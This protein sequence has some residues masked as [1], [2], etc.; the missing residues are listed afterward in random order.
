MIVPWR[1]KTWLFSVPLPLKVLLDHI[2]IF[3]LLFTPSRHLGSC[4][5]MVIRTG[6]NTVMGRI[7]ALGKVV[8]S[9]GFRILPENGMKT[10]VSMHFCLSFS[11]DGYN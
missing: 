3:L 2:F 5:G 11:F 10:E 7:A 9:I 4:T 1:R 8:S 6:D